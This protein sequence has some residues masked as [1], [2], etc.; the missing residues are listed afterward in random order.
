MTRKAPWTTAPA[1]AVTVLGLIAQT[2]LAPATASSTTLP[3]TS[4]RQ[5]VVDPANDHVFVSA[6]ATGTSI[7]VMNFDGTLDTTIT[8]EL[9][10]SGMVLVN[11]DLW[12]AAQNSDT[13]DEIDTSTLTRV[14]SY[15]T[16]SVTKPNNV[17]YA[18]GQLWFSYGE[19][20][21]FEGG[22]AS[23]DPSDG[24]V[25]TYASS[26]GFPTY[27]PDMAS[28][29][30]LPNTLFT[31][32]SGLEPPTV[33]TYDIS[34]APSLQMSRF[35][36]ELA[37]IRQV[38]LSP[39]QTKLLVAAGA[40]YVIKSFRLSD[41]QPSGTDYPTGPY[42]TGVDVTTVGGGQIAAGLY[43]PYDPDVYVFTQDETT[44]S[45]SYDFNTS[46]PSGLMWDAGVAFSP[47][48]T[49]LFA[50]T[51][52][53][54]DEV[55]FNVLTLSASSTTSSTSTSSTTTLT[56]TPPPTTTTTTTTLPC[57]TARCTLEA[58][59]MSSACAGEAI[60][61][62]VTRKFSTAETLI[63]QAATAPGNKGR[64]VR[65]R[66]KTVLTHAGEGAERAAKGKRA[67]ISAACA[68]ALEDAVNAVR[69]GLGS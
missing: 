20:G 14:H 12:V 6:G 53:L 51:G 19:C 8:N 55:I 39:D 16:G 67:T 40:P 29:P 64:E 35:M 69:S 38:A 59:L 18:G 32:E 31:W 13:I 43:A 5:L 48:A 15:S 49:V 57:A 44:P 17:A 10:A 26:I 27:C 9:G 2:F 52:D 46:A 1:A 45:Y 21:F 36:T 28:F 56:T 66:A 37:F 42:P 34:G 60:P 47:D 3:F 22:I 65:H 30:S 24:A 62:R 33:N 61:A 23:M 4:F 68:A 25:T 11:G 7:A 41:L 50:V 54:G 63:D 58:A